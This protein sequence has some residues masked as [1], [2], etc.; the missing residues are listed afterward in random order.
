MQPTW[1]FPLYYTYSLACN[2]SEFEVTRLWARGLG[3]CGKSSLWSAGLEPKRLVLLVCTEA[4]C[5]N[6]V[7][8]G[9]SICSLSILLCVAVWVH[10]LPFTFSQN[11]LQTSLQPIMDPEGWRIFSVCGVK[12]FCL[13]ASVPSLELG[14][15]RETDCYAAMWID[16]FRARPLWNYKD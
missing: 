8:W 6:T 5:S 2:W 14:G 7:S 1:C 13:F 15:Q 3:S 11:H 4:R 16:W 10:S 9:Y 12:S